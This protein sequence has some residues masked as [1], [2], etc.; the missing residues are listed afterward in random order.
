MLPLCSDI[1]GK[2]TTPAVAKAASVRP[3]LVVLL[4]LAVGLA[5]AGRVKLVTFYAD[6]PDARI[7]LRVSG[8]APFVL[9][10]ANKELPL[11]LKLFEDRKAVTL[12]FQR[13]G[14]F[15]EERILQKDGTE[16]H[17]FSNRDRYPDASQGPVHLTPKSDGASR[18][19]QLQLFARTHAVGLGL[20]GLAL[21]VAAAWAYKLTRRA[22][23]VEVLEGQRAELDT[24]DRFVFKDLG[25]YRLLQRLGEGG[26]GAVYKGVPR[27]TMEEKEA[28]AIK[29][30]DKGVSQDP[31]SRKRFEREVLISKKLVHPNIVRLIDWGE[32]DGLLYMVMEILQGNPLYKYMP[33]EGM[34]LDQVERVFTLLARGLEEAHRQG[35]VHRDLK[36]GNIFLLDKGG[37]K[38][39]DFGIARGHNFTV[40][41]AT[42]QAM[43]TPAY[44]APEQLMGEVDPRSDQYAAGVLLFEMVTGVLPFKDPDPFVLAMQHVNRPAPRPSVLRKDL[45][46]EVEEVILKMMSKSPE[47]RFG[48]V[49]EAAAA[50]RRALERRA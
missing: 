37:L 14:Y 41:T 33:A 47:G 17:Y 46:I 36:P 49:E 28:V 38:I 16:S 43:G 1:H 8:N 45:P 20:A 30:L 23:R 15:D 13:E 3:V 31:E 44:M 12:T 34:D 9:G 26:M 42:G 29:I 24:S 6:P 11:D 18:L 32:Q 4:T 21:G 39:L 35:V 19:I 10:Y 40:A 48:N 2:Y 5:Q 27:E 22:K 25:P 7:L 50:L